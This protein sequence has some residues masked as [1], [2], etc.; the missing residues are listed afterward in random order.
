[1]TN[2]IVLV[3]D[4]HFIHRIGSSILSKHGIDVTTLGSGAELLAYLED[5]TPDL[6]LLDIMM[7][8][9]DG[10]ETLTKLRKFEKHRGINEIP[11]IFLTSDET[12]ESESKGF[13]MGVSDYI[14]KPFKSEILIKRIENVLNR[15]QL[16]NR[17]HEEATI[18]NLTGLLNKSATNDKLEMV[19]RRKP[20]FLMMIDLDSF[21]LVNDI[22]GHDAG[23]KILI[24]FS[25]L[26]KKLMG[27]DDIIG[28]IGGD[29]FTA[30]S[31]SFSTKSDLQKFSD[32]L[33]SELTTEAKQ[34]LG[35][36]MD[37]PLG[38]S[39]GVIYLRGKSEDYAEAL[40]KADKAL[41]QVKNNG[42][43][44]FYVYTD[45][46]A[47][48]DSCIM[49]LETLTKIMSE[50][51]VAASALKLDKSSFVGVYRFVMRYAMRYHRNACKLLISLYAD[52]SISDKDALEAYEM[53]GDHIGNILRRSD[54]LMQVRNNMY[55][56][57]L[58]DIKEEAVEQVVGNIIRNWRE[59]HGDLL[60][61]T[62]ETEFLESELLYTGGGDKLWVAVVD[63]DEMNLKLAERILTKSDINV[64]KLSSGE[65]LMVFLKDHRPDLI[66]L[67][68]NMPG[69][70]G[71]ETLTKLR[72]EETEIADIPV[73]FLTSENDT[74]TEKKALK[75]GA[76][77]FIK[78]PFIPEI[79]T[80]R[81]KQIAELLRLQKRLS[82]EVAKKTKENEQLFL[83][84]VSS[85]A[86]AI[87]AKDTYTNGH[88]S[89]VAEYAKEISRR[90]GYNMKEQSDIYIMALLHDVGKI[91]VPD[92]IINKPDKLTEEEFNEIK[93]H[94]VIGSQILKNIN[95]MPKLSVGARWHHERYDGTGYPDGL[96]GEEIPEEARIIAVADS[97]DAM[98]S[99]R[100]YRNII[101]QDKIREEFV[102]G[103]GTQFDPRF[104]EIMIK[105]IDEDPDYTMR[106]GG[107][108]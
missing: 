29:E 87:D 102:I 99:N 104:A 100:S 68:V 89:R 28:R 42:K 97:Y 101:T 4:D 107:K 77:D 98:S 1:M 78:K 62:Y 93:K 52:E 26:L 53:F 3:D 6:V 2:H 47:P 61:I 36:D 105:M 95:E 84:V 10:F 35:E 19:V 59:K 9:M 73:V 70:D 49:D 51:N 21:K 23:D 106:E 37:I 40:K 90:Y 13:E 82:D 103:S 85:L 46:I 88:S 16:I 64:S 17:F 75:L 18:D 94:P 15:Q 96:A 48:D 39:I 67:D 41:Y 56:I 34:I 44:G 71:F 58:T 5:N 54:L 33:N 38:A 32:N 24:C 25:N 60:R 65:D 63:D 8:E 22:Y 55:F 14:R 80:L 7:P 66:L 31:V 76:K 30:F 27:S 91:G 83:N 81:V 69:M 43:H 79:L 12:N 57:V 20:G 74:D 11:V 92:S 108:D 86:G 45:D 50:R 72:A